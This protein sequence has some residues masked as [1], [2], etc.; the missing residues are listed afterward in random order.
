M[1][2]TK[3]SFVLDFSEEESVNYDILGIC[4]NAPS[5]QI[6]WRINQLFRFNLQYSDKLF[7][8]YNKKG[9]ETSFPYYF[10]EDPDDFHHVY[11][12]Q[13]NYEGNKLIPELFQVDYFI[14]FVN[15]EL[16]D[17]EEFRQKIKKDIDLIQVTYRVEPEKYKSI[18]NIIFE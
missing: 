3:K 17:I 12:I 6:A 9:V 11:M 2:K 5:Y 8:C 4:T 18:E 1:A 13:N 16:F 10:H 7:V 15:N 14:F